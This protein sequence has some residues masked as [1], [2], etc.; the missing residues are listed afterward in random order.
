[1]AIVTGPSISSRSAFLVITWIWSWPGFPGAVLAGEGLIR[2]S[3]PP[4]AYL[5]IEGLAVVGHQAY[6]SDH[7]VV[8]LPAIGRFLHAVID[9]DRLGARLLDLGPDHDVGVFPPPRAAA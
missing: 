5:G 3:T 4:V 8:H 2:P 9:V 6:A 7:D 1:V